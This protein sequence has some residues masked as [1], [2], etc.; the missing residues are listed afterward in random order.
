MALVTDKPTVIRYKLI[1]HAASGSSNYNTGGTDL[2]HVLSHAAVG[3][4]RDTENLVKQTSGTHWI[5]S[6]FLGENVTIEVVLGQRS[7]D[8]LKLASRPQWQNSVGSGL[9]LKGPQMK[10]GYRAKAN[11]YTT[12][13]QLRP[14]VQAGTVDNTLPHLF[15]PYAWCI[16]VGPRQYNDKGRHF[17]ATVL[18]IVALYDETNGVAVYEGDPTVSSA[19]PS[20]GGEA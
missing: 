13:L 5:D 11:S 12:R 15:L 1:D 3:F 2:G 20:L 4:H 16:D 6:V 8:V 9:L 14:V 18:T 10:P 7:S 17:E 19:F